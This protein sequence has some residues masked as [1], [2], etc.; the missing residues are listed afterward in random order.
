MYKTTYVSD[1]LAR[2]VSSGTSCPE[3]I[4]C[5]APMCLGWAYVWASVGE[6]CTPEWRKNRMRVAD[7]HYAQEIRDNCPVLLGKQPFC[8]GCKWANTRVFD[9]QG[10]CRWLLEQVGIYLYGGGATTQWE[11]KSNWVAQG[12]IATMPRGRFNALKR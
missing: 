7:Q 4:R 8:D 5:L 12:E 10:F 2:L 11:T 1:E 6:M 3:I 9:C